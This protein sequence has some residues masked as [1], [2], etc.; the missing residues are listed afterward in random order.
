QFEVRVAAEAV[1]DGGAGQAVAVGH[2]DGVDAGVVERGDDALDVGD[3]VLVPDG[4]A[5]V[6]QGH[7]GD[8]DLPGHVQTP[9]V[10]SRRSATSDAA[11]AAAEV[12]MSR[13]PA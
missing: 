4:V 8:E 7:V 13:F 5:A 10:W 11:R 12:M 3:G 9:T 6:A 2:L 1:G